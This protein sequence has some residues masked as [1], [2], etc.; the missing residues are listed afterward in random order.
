M[1]LLHNHRVYNGYNIK[2][3]SAPKSDESEFY[4]NFYNSKSFQILPSLQSLAI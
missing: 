2:K 1:Q 4:L 3:I